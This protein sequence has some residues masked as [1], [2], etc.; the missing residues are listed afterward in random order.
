MKLKYIDNKDYQWLKAE[1][2]KEY[3]QLSDD[4]KEFF[5]KYKLKKPKPYRLK[6]PTIY[7]DSMFVILSYKNNVILFD[8]IEELFSVGKLEDNQLLFDGNFT[9]LNENINY[10]KRL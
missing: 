1:I 2:S 7:D 4:N 6:E 10:L 5:D 3:T 8:D 9:S